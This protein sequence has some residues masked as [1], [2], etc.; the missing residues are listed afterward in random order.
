VGQHE[1]RVT[2]NSRCCK[3]LVATVD[4]RSPVPNHPDEV[5]VVYLAM[6]LEPATVGLSG[7]PRNGQLSC[8]ELGLSVVAEAPRQV[9]LHDA[10]WNGT[11]SVAGPDKPVR[12]VAVSLRAGETNT[13]PWPSE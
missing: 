12:A 3:E 6:P 8:P 2:I 4:V 10:V 9:R 1:A 7:A 13:V 11:C 5:Q